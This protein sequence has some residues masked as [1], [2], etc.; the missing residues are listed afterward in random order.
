M[1]KLFLSRLVGVLN[2]FFLLSH[3]ALDFNL[4]WLTILHPS[5]KFAISYTSAK[6]IYSEENKL[7]NDANGKRTFKY[8]GVKPNDKLNTSNK[9]SKMHQKVNLLQQEYYD[10]KVVDTPQKLLQEGQ[11]QHS[12]IATYIGK[13][14][15]D[16]SAILHYNDAQKISYS[17]ELIPQPD[18]NYYLNQI[19]GDYD[20]DCPTDIEEQVKKWFE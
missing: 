16:R 4:G 13:V 7:A 11:K 15:N 10:V 3:Q 1:V 18:G 8:Y 2:R 14:V 19:Y 9:W 12:C 20:K 5:K 17:F 6:K